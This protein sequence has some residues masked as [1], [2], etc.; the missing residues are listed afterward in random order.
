MTFAL[1]VMG[2][3][4]SEQVRIRLEESPTAKEELGTPIQ[5]KMNFGE[6]LTEGEAADV[7]DVS[8]PKASGKVRADVEDEFV[9]DCILTVNGKTIDVLE[10]D[11]AMPNAVDDAVAPSAE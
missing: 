9:L 1:G 4:Q 3:E 2:A 5:V 8:G 10:D 7:F 6:S 11:D